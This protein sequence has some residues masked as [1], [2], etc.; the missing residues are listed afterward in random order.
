MNGHL[1]PESYAQQ[2]K[3]AEA[4]KAQ[5][6]GQILDKHALERLGRVRVAD[7]GTAAQVELYLVQL[8]QQ[9]KLRERVTDA[10]LREV[11]IILTEKKE[12]TIRRK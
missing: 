1:N 6:L 9:G 3:Q 11:L 7:P 12:I 4:M 5:L 2:L 8:F 10:K